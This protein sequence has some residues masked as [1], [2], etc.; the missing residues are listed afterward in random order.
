MYARP[1]SSAGSFT[2]VARGACLVGDGRGALPCAGRASRPL[3]LW[4][5]PG[6]PG[7]HRA[8]RPSHRAPC[9]GACSAGPQAGRKERH[10]RG[11]GAWHPQGTLRVCPRAPDPASG[12]FPGKLQ[13]AARRGLECAA[14]QET[15]ARGRALQGACATGPV[16]C[17]SAIDHPPGRGHGPKVADLAAGDWER[18]KCGPS[19]NTSSRQRAWG[20]CGNFRVAPTRGPESHRQ[21]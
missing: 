10:C 20:A 16:A 2:S 4:V 3:R 15:C 17:R 6:R 5:L 1:R 18:P 8:R 14:L 11:H 9:Y 21:P 7:P 13:V 12:H 19:R